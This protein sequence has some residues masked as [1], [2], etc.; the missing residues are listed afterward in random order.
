MPIDVAQVLRAAA[1]AAIQE[2]KES[3]KPKKQRLTTGRAVLIGAGLVTGGRLIAGSK[4][5]GLLDRVTGDEPLGRVAGD[6]APDVDA[7][8]LLEEEEEVYEHEPEADEDL[9]E[10]A[11][12]EENEAEADE[13]FGQAEPEAEAEADEEELGDDDEAEEPPPPRRR[14]RSRA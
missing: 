3:S 10:E 11:F 1:E 7:D 6:D 8:E 4:A 2:S 14:G 5:R 9:E 13:D 12:D